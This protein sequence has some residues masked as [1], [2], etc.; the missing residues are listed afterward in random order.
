MESVP[1][2][3]RGQNWFS[4]QGSNRMRKLF[5]WETVYKEPYAI[6]LQG[7]VYT[8][9]IGRDLSKRCECTTAIAVLHIRGWLTTATDPTTRMKSNALRR[10][11]S[12]LLWYSACRAWR[13]VAG[14][15]CVLANG[16]LLFAG[17]TFSI[18]GTATCLV[19]ISVPQSSRRDIV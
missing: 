3:A 5:A 6:C 12:K 15:C 4:L 2:N 18:L 13:K 17:S 10:L 14:I 11:S 19:R 9:C 8:V 7:A 16:D 1:A